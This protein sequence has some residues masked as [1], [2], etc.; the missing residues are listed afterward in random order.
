MGLSC[1]F[2]DNAA[3]FNRPNFPGYK[4]VQFF[5]QEIEL[6]KGIIKDIQNVRVSEFPKRV[7]RDFPVS[8]IPLSIESITNNILSYYQKFDDIFIILISSELHPLYGTVSEVVKKLRG[9]ASI[10]L[11]D[12]RSLAIGQGQIVQ[13]A[14]ELINRNEN[15]VVI[16]EKLRSAIPH[17]YTLLCTPNFSYL[18]KSGFIDIGQSISGDL[19]GFLPI[20]TLEEGRL[21]P[22]EKVK[23]H[24]NVIDYFIEFIDE[25]DKLENIS[26][27]QP[28]ALNHNE[29]RLIRQHVDEFHPDAHYSEHTI[30]PHLASLIGP[31]GMGIVIAEKSSS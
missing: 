3:Q 24:R 13:L 10:H 12:S 31:Q 1:I 27:I 30:N 2:T 11:I 6:Q 26:F 23:N 18:Q 4:Q 16:E 9:R 22:V 21:N 7:T 28:N 15:G 14:A 8:L 17:T 19:L 20:F 25:F 5:S 29:T